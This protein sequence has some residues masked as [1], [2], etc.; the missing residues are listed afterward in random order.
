MKRNREIFDSAFRE[1][2]RNRF[3]E[4]SFRFPLRKKKKKTIFGRLMIDAYDL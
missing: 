2:L 4:N 1:T 3:G